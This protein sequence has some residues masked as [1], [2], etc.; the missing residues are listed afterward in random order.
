MK[1]KDALVLEAVTHTDREKVPLEQKKIILKDVLNKIQNG[2]FKINLRNSRVS[3]IE[4]IA[5][6][7]KNEQMQKL[8]YYASGKKYK[9]EIPDYDERIN[10]ERKLSNGKYKKEIEEYCKG[11][12][13]D[14]LKNK[15][16]PFVDNLGKLYQI[17]FKTPGSADE[18]Y[19]KFNYQNGELS[20]VCC[21]DS[22]F[23]FSSKSYNDRNSW[24]FGNKE[25]MDKVRQ[26]MKNKGLDKQWKD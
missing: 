26:D 18:P 12:L 1:F 6:Q 3:D 5:R 9:G 24:K 21:H 14:Y 7:L 22:K 20:L 23:S 13:V 16:Y 19:V 25:A 4:Y 10:A 17:V 2:Q 15:K 11:P 8:A